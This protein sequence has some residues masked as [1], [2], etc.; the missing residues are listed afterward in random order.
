MWEGVYTCGWVYIH[1]GGFT[2]IHWVG[3]HTCGWVYMHMHVEVRGRLQVTSSV[4]LCLAFV[5][6]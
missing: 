3:E 6:N 4:A 1:V 2:Y 5:L